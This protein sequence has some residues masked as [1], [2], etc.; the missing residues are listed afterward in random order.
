MAIQR[1]AELA[2][3]WFQTLPP[4]RRSTVLR[5]GCA[6]RRMSPLL[7]DRLVNDCSPSMHRAQ[8]SMPED[9]SMGVGQCVSR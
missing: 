6:L 4:D 2:E 3:T 8:R 7:L 9:S 5:N 1:R